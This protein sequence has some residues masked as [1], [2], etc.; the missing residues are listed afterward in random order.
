MQPLPT[1]PD[2]SR[3]SFIGK[4]RINGNSAYH[5]RITTPDNFKIGLYTN[6][7]GYPLL[8]SSLDGMSTTARIA[9]L[10]FSP[11]SPDHFHL[12]SACKNVDPILLPAHKA[13]TAFPSL[14]SIWKNLDIISHNNEGKKSPHILKSNRFAQY[15]FSTFS[16][17]HLMH[18]IT[19]TEAEA[20]TLQ[21]VSIEGAFSISYS[22]LLKL[23]QVQLIPFWI[24]NHHL[25]IFFNLLLFIY[26][27]GCGYTNLH[28]H[29]YPSR[30]F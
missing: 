29:K 5:F 18:P 26:F 19:P 10:D 11:P 23:G 25:I 15:S 27:V 2:F 9:S 8:L 1:G 3:F 28:E 14:S 17:L 21:L 13:A 7:S 24:P 22:L 30:F 4:S 20:R 6:A 16:A 12:P